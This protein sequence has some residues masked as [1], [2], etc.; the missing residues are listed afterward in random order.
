MGTP[1]I[2]YFPLDCQLDEK[3]QLIEAEFGLKGFAVVVKLLQRIYG[4]NGYYCE[5]TKDIEL[6]F[7]MQIGEGRNFVSDIVERSLERG[8]FSGEKFEKYHI[9]TSKGIQKRYLEAVSRRKKVELNEDYLIVPATKNNERVDISRKNVDISRKNVDISAQR[10]E[11]KRKEEDSREQERRE[12]VDNLKN[13]EE[14]RKSLRA[15][16]EAFYSGRE[17]HD[18]K[19]NV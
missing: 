11:E 18:E 2:P 5:W 8:I 7:S 16:A 19:D 10:K 9:L 12:P 4:I 17:E 13:I 14:F 15:K 3:F 6:L 1:G